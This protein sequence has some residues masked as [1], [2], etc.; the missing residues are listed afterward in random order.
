MSREP[1]SIF[2]Y[3]FPVLVA[4]VIVLIFAR[5]LLGGGTDEPGENAFQSAF[6]YVSPAT[7]EATVVHQIG[8]N[9]QTVGSPEKVYSKELVSA[10]E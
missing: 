6:V 10:K 2:S 5:F 4:L 8:P 9:E 3:I 1:N 7:D